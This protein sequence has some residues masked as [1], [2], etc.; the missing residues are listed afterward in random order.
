MHWLSKRLQFFCVLNSGSVKQ[1]SDCIHYFF[2][3]LSF[4]TNTYLETLSAED[5]ESLR[6]LQSNVENRLDTKIVYTDISTY[7]RLTTEQEKFA[8]MIKED[9][10]RIRISPVN[11]TRFFVLELMHKRSKTNMLWKLR[12]IGKVLS[13]TITGHERFSVEYLHEYELKHITITLTK[14]DFILPKFW[15]RNGDLIFDFFA[16]K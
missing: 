13:S 16:L 6:Y 3:T 11:G 15:K 4:R 8:V 12:F 5:I 10:K 9:E 14:D 2:K 1:S 7:R